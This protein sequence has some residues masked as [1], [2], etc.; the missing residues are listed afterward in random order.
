[1][2]RYI[3]VR[4]LEMNL[5]IE[6][7]KIWGEHFA[8][9]PKLTYARAAVLHEESHNPNLFVDTYA[10]NQGYLLAEFSDEKEARNWLKEY[11]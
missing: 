11:K 5:T 6:E 1:L 7:Q 8:N 4:K 9:H 2:T 10:F 3:D